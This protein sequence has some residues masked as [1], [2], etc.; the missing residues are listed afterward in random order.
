MERPATAGFYLSSE[1]STSE[2]GSQWVL[3]TFIRDGQK[4]VLAFSELQ[5]HELK[6]CFWKYPATDTTTKMEEDIF[7]SCVVCCRSLSGLRPLMLYIIPPQSTPF[8]HWPI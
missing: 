1:Y 5:S 7:C 2:R 4:W 6:R 3:W 8:C